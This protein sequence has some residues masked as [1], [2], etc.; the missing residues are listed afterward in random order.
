MILTTHS[1]EEADVL[2]NRIGIVN[3]GVM[4]CIGSQDRLK[5]L[6]GGGYHLFLNCDRKCSEKEIQVVREFVKKKR[7]ICIIVHG[8]HGTGRRRILFGDRK[9]ELF[10]N[11]GSLLSPNE[12]HAAPYRRRQSD[13]DSVSSIGSQ[14]VSEIQNTN[15]KTEHKVRP[16]VQIIPQEVSFSVESSST[17]DEEK[18]CSSPRQN[19]GSSSRSNVSNDTGIIPKLME[20]I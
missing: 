6:Y 5:E 9:N 2:C 18:R 16:K 3:N 11:N 20:D 12:L 1:M 10:D 4:T 8:A 13:D 14:G 17:F 7:N 15:T 19:Y